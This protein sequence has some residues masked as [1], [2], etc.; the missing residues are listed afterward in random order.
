MPLLLLKVFLY[1]YSK[2]IKFKVKNFSK[3][4][5]EEF[6]KQWANIRDAILE[7]FTLIKSFGF[8]EHSLTSKNVLIP[9][10]Y[11]IYH[12]NALFTSAI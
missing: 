8:T 7:V 11:Y 2:D 5:A 12:R 6:E 1:L 4:N 10:I 9:I 3:E